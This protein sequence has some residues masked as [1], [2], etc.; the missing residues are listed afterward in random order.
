MCLCAAAKARK[1]VQGLRL[2]F[3][4]RFVNKTFCRRGTR[5][6]GTAISAAMRSAATTTAPPHYGHMRHHGP[7]GHGASQSHRHAAG[8]SQARGVA[9]IL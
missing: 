2:A 5:F 7:H 1:R 4:F 3:R 6:P 9:P 8:L